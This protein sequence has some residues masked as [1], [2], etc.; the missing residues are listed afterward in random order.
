MTIIDLIDML[1][2][3]LVDTM[4]PYLWSDEV[5]LQLI[6]ETVEDISRRANLYTDVYS[7]IPITKNV[8]EYTLNGVAMKCNIYDKDRDI[9]E[10]PLLYSPSNIMRR[11]LT[12][13]SET[14]RP[15]YYSN[16]LSTKTFLIYPIPDDSYYLLAMLANIPV[17][18][19]DSIFDFPEQELCI[20]GVMCR[21][22]SMPDTETYNF[23]AFQQ[24]YSRYTDKLN[25]FKGKF[26]RDT[27]ISEVSGIHKGLL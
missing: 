9:R 7:I 17:Y 18:S 5:L 14:G 12:G 4:E 23:Q 16:D 11:K 22:F 6:N 3:R 25:E 10:E 1:R 21:A 2:T 20:L 24:Y 19:M 13:T 15:V 27:S 26:I 8:T